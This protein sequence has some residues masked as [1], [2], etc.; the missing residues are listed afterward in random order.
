[1]LFEQSPADFQKRFDVVACYVQ[2][3]GNFL[4]LQRQKEKPNGDLWGLPAGK[5]DQKEEY[6]D[7]IQREIE[8][9]TGIS[10]NRKD[11]VYERM[12]YVRHDHIDFHYH[13]FSCVLMKRP[14]IILRSEE[15][16][17]YQWVTP[18]DSLMV[19]QVPDQEVCTKVFYSM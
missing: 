6:T 18:A 2:H 19:A 12:F 11:L 15:H 13:T 10:V 5:V 4:M 7:A 14:E 3:A 8:E 17:A 16:C 1:M 9:E